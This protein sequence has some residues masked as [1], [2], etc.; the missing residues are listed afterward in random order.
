MT[1]TFVEGMD[2]TNI[3]HFLDQIFGHQFISFEDLL[4]ELMHGDLDSIKEIS[5]Q[6]FKDVFFGNLEQC[7][8]LFLGIFLLGIF[9]LLLHGLS[10]LFS[11]KKIS[12]FSSYFI[13][14]F[15]SLILMKCFLR[16]YEQCLTFL[17]EMKSFCAILMPSL[18]M[19]LGISGGPVTAAAYYEFQLLLLF[20][21]ENVMTIFVM[22]MARLVCVLYV[23]NQLPE[24]NRFGGVIALLKKIIIFL[25]RSAIFAAIGGSMLQAGLMPAIDGVQSKLIIKTVSL[26]PGLG[27]Y[28]TTITETVLRGVILVKNSIGF[29]G[30]FILFIMCFKPAVTTLMY[31]FVVRLASAILQISGEKKFTAHVWKM[32]DCFFL[33]SRIQLFSSGMFFIAIAV[34]TLGMNSGH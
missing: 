19:V 9:A 6:Y 4:E 15:V 8:S 5:L 18:C 1:D 20:V 28:A 16:S 26:I 3:D 7:K 30:I 17:E 29:I 10:D 22:P 34:A 2:F 23:L 12:I 21:I 14:L 25:T 33:L 31:G 13:F 27:D 24:G 11:D 32:A